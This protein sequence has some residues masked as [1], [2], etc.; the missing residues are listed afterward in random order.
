MTKPT[1]FEVREIRNRYAREGST[2][3]A[4]S[5]DYDFDAATVADIIR[6]IIMPNLEQFPK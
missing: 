2:Y 1:E 3:A 5:R 4:L 6:R